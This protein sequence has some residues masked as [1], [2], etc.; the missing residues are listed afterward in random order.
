MVYRGVY[1]FGWVLFDP[2]ARCLHFELTMHNS[3]GTFITRALLMGGPS[4]LVSSHGVW[5][6]A[7]SICPTIAHWLTGRVTVGNLLDER[8]PEVHPSEI[9]KWLAPSDLQPIKAFGVTFVNSL[10]ERL[11]EEIAHGDEDRKSVV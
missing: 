5:R 3:S 9:L 10:L 8:G 7:T 11:V 1:D 2:D 6:D 4:V